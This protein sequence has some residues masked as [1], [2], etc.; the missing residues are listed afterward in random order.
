MQS[1][2]SVKKLEGAFRCPQCSFLSTQYIEGHPICSNCGLVIDQWNSM[3]KNDS[4]ESEQRWKKNAYHTKG[5]LNLGISNFLSISDSTEEKI[6]ITLASILDIGMKLGMNSDAIETALDIYEDLAKKCIFKGKSIKAL[7]AAIVYIANKKNGK[8]CGIR[9]IARVACI[10]PNK[11]FKCYAFIIEKLGYTEFYCP[12]IE[13]Y[14]TRICR[15]LATNR[16][17]EDIAKKIIL[18]TKEHIQSMGT[19][20]SIVAASIYI[21][22]NVLGEKRTQRE[23][24]DAIGITE[25]TIRTRY[26]EITRKL[27]IT[28]ML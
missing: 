19:V 15:K 14:V 23:I 2:V 11:I 22:S 3:Q 6:A 28:T 4:K 16:R 17:I 5:S 7:S 25:A 21:S 10:K 13:E 18:T 1:K 12:S 26:K 9:E 24:A 27:H 20:S 8:I